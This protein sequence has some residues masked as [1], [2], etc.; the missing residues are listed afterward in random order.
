MSLTSPV[1]WISDDFSFY[2]VP[3]F[4]IFCIFCHR[5]N[6]ISQK[7]VWW[8]WFWLRVFWYA[9]FPFRFDDYVG[10]V[11]G[12]GSEVFLTNRSRVQMWRFCVCCVCAN[13]SQFQR[14][15]THQNV[16]ALKFLV[17]HPNFTISFIVIVM[18]WLCRNHSDRCC[19]TKNMI[20]HD[21]M[22]YIRWPSNSDSGSTKDTTLIQCAD[23]R[24]HQIHELWCLGL[25]KTSQKFH[26]TAQL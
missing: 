14:W 5:K 6:N 24:D 3:C 16:L 11:C 2:C 8:W 7:W 18:V 15:S 1:L 23:G 10:H 22:G 25:N 21:S 20:Q 26:P 13:R 17:F 12:L 4:Y 9:L 19:F